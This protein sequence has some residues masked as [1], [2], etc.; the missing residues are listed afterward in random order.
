MLRWLI[1]FVGVLVLL[2]LLAVGSLA[3][4]TLEFG[5]RPASSLRPIEIAPDIK[6]IEANGIR[7]AYIEEGQGPLILLFHGY[8]ETARSWKV[9]QQRLAAAGFHV[10]A[11]YM[12]GY[13]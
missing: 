2:G 9:V 12:R 6:F 1:L 3:V 4:T 8:P 10:V 11:P 13:P 7:F 5:E